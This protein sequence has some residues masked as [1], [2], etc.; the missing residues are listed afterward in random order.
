MTR[1]TSESCNIINVYRSRGANTLTF[2]EDLQKLIDMKHHTLVIGDFNICY[3]KNPNH[4]IFKML[5]DLGF[6]QLVHKPTHIDGGTID[7]VFSLCP[8]QEI[9]YHVRQRAHFFLDH[10]IISVRYVAFVS[11][12]IY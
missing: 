5:I 3:R 6:R 7:L 2:K 8:D 10:D 9:K 1:I 11:H 12:F 4:E